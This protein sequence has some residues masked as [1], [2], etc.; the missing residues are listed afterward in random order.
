METLLAMNARTIVVVTLH[1]PGVTSKV[2]LAFGFARFGRPWENSIA[3][4]A[5]ITAVATDIL[6]NS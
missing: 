2:P 1:V 3:G 5:V 4:I 6:I